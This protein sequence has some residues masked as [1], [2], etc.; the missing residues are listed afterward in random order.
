[1][2]VIFLSK[3]FPIVN[4]NVLVFLHSLPTYVPIVPEVGSA[5]SLPSDQPEDPVS[6]SPHVTP[7]VTVA[8]PIFRWVTE[9][10]RGLVTLSCFTHLVNGQVEMGT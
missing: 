1:M 9:A 2:G 10:E 4:E 6:R 3:S 7:P 8:T 5:T